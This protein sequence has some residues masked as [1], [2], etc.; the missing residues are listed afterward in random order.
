[1]AVAVVAFVFVIQKMTI[2]VIPLISS[3]IH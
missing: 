2:H 1:V 3:N